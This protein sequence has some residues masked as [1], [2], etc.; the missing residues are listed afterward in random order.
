MSPL[1]RRAFVSAALASLLVGCGD[2]QAARQ[3]GKSPLAH[4][5]R[6]GIIRSVDGIASLSG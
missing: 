5:L 2:T 6:D 3:P 4:P 1:S